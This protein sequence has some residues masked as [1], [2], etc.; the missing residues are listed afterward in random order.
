M[1]D[2]EHAHA[3]CVWPGA[4][5]GCYHRNSILSGVGRLGEVV[6]QP[7]CILWKGRFDTMPHID[8]L[9]LPYFDGITLDNVAELVDHM[10]TR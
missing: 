2:Y 3:P 7:P 8:L 10:G 1:T 9:G 4:G 6:Q 5:Q